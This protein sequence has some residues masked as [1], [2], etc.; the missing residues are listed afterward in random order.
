MPEAS[1]KF[2][3]RVNQYITWV[4]VSKGKEPS[5]VIKGKMNAIAVIIR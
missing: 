1:A 4:M 2:E 3:I 5:K